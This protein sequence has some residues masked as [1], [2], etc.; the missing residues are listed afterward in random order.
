[1][2]YLFFGRSYVHL[3]ISCLLVIKICEGFWWIWHA[4]CCIL[5]DNREDYQLCDLSLLCTAFGEV[6]VGLGWLSRGQRRESWSGLRKISLFCPCLAPL[7]SKIPHSVWPTCTFLMLQLSL[8][9]LHGHA[10]IPWTTQLTR[11]SSWHQVH[12]CNCSGLLTPPHHSWPPP[13][14]STEGHSS[15]WEWFTCNIN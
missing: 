13:M 6:F 9:L 10:A 2:I 3:Y 7:F 11:G 12:L 15:L 1:M 8:P 14:A 5:S 4:G